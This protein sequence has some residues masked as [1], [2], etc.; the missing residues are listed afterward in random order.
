MNFLKEITIKIKN[1][2]NVNFDEGL[3]IY[4]SPIDELSKYA[5]ELRDELCGKKVDLCSIMN[6]K[7]GKCSEDCNFCAQS[8]HFKTGVSEYPLVS[9]KEALELAK[10]NEAEGVDRFSLITSGL[11]LKGKDFDN[12]LKIYSNLAKNTNIDLCASFGILNKEQLREIKDIGIK[13][14][15]HNLESSRDFYKTICTTHSYESRIETLKNAKLEGLEIC[16]GG[17]IG[18]GET[19]EDRINLALTLQELE[20][21]SIPINVLMPIKGTPLENQDKLSE[22]H[23][24]RTIATFRFIN[25]KAN[26]RLA[27]GRMLIKNQGKEAF[28]FGANATITGNYLTTCGNKT[29]DDRKMLKDLGFELKEI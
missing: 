11:G 14:Y 2:Y 16:S 25:P 4:N 28:N 10:E 8:I 22:E 5:N 13:R 26:I 3:K 20:V 19:I 18:M 21:M 23:I 6:A 15:H 9:S 29:K 1:N 17:I 12:A 7:S 27:G 24:L